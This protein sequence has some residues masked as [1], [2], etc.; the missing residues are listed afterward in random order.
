L[1]VLANEREIELILTYKCNWFCEYCCV[2]THKQLPLSF[3]DIK[4][5]L[6]KVLPNYNVTLSGGEVGLL[7]ENIILFVIEYL[8]N[9]N[10]SISLNTNGLFIKKFPHLLFYFDEI[11][12][13]CSENLNPNDNIIKNINHNN[14][15]YLLVLTDNN[16]PLFNDFLSI[17]SDII[18][19]AIPASNPEFIN[20]ITLSDS[21]KAILLTKYFKKISKDS[22]RRL[23][24]EKKFNS[25][26]YI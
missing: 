3:D 26:I 17:H 15:Q 10:C 9:I 8:K 25:I 7:S 4:L 12:Y 16:F 24:S 5:K 6:K 14:I 23:I 19:N 20:N 1:S 21:N 2:D 22:S 13:H 11:L 18:F